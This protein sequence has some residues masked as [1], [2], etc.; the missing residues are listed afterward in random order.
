MSELILDPEIPAVDVAIARA[1]LR[2]RCAEWFPDRMELY[3]MVY[4]RRFDRLWEQF[5][6]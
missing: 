2:E 1:R 6:D 3:D 4:E 5:R